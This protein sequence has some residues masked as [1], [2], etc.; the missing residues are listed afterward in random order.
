MALSRL[1]IVAVL[2]MGCG[3]G[4][5]SADL[6]AGDSASGRAAPEARAEE[7]DTLP[8]PV[9]NGEPM[10]YAED[11]AGIPPY[12]GAIVHLRDTSPRPF[13]VIEAFTP[14]PWEKVAAFYEESLDG[15]VVTHGVDMMIFH[16][17]PDDQATITVAPW[18]QQDLPPDAPRVL[19]QARTSIG[20][21]WR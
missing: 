2:L 4:D 1:A 13:H 16:M 20:A 21:A 10:P 6:P 7:S 19:L 8:P 9:A 18:L 12:P 11:A 5:R 15:W 17:G 14:D 3:A